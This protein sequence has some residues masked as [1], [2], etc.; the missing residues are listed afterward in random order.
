MASPSSE[1]ESEASTGEE[2]LQRRSIEDSS[3]KARRLTRSAG[4][5]SVGVMVSRVLGLVREQVLAY[6]FSARFG[7][8]AFY[9]AFRIPNLLRDMFGEGALSKAF[10]STFAEIEEKEGR[11]A[12]LRLVNVVGNALVVLVGTLMIL[13][14]VYADVIVDLALPGKGFD[15]AFPPGEGFGYATKRDLTIGLT[16]VMFPFIV[17]VSVAALVMG[18]LN[19][20][21][22]FLVPALASSFFNVGSVAVGLVGYALA[23]RLGLH[24][25]MGM[26]FGVVAGGALQLLWQLPSLVALGYRYRPVFAFRDP[27]LYKV[28]RLFGPGAIVASTVQV[29]VLVNQ[30]FASQGE[31]WLSW[32][33]QS[34]R[35]LHLPIGLVGVAIS[36]ATLPTLSRAVALGDREEFRETFS[37]ASRLVILFTVPATVGLLALAEPIVRLIFQQGRFG[38]EDTL[39]VAGALR[40]YALGLISFAAVKIVTDGFY[41]IQDIRPPMVVSLISMASNAVLNW[42]FVVEL[43][44]DHRGLALATSGTMTISLV[45]LWLVFRRR[46]RL[47]RLDGRRVATTFVKTAVASAV[48][49]TGSLFVFQAL[50]GRFGHDAIWSRLLQVGAA[51]ATAIVVYYGGCRLLRVRELDHALA[52]FLPRRARAEVT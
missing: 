47:G 3:T 26:A 41:A 12:A 51:I 8:D 33:T 32:I 46:S 9:A 14:I 15:V 31:G 16:R 2:E 1:T 4:T 39:Q 10:V 17:L 5:V 6:L 19:A 28:A 37:H 22:R 43:G 42:L 27:W 45:L 30:Y 29:N 25:T 7:L 49:G 44:L 50:D 52:A 23:P 48:M 21:G 18:V 20:R 36:S 35:I 24:P 13:G 38:P 11:E 40:C 34:F